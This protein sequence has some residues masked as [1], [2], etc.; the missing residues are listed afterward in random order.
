MMKVRAYL[1]FVLLGLAWDSNFIFM[2]WATGLVTAT[3][4]TLLQVMFGCLSVFLFA[5]ATKA[6]RWSHVRYAHH[7]FIMSLLAVIVYHF[8]CTKN[9]PISLSSGTGMLSGTMPGLTLL[10]SYLFLREEHFS[11]K[12]I[13]G[14]VVGLVGV[15]LIA[16]PWSQ[17]MKIDV[18]SVLYIL[19]GVVSLAGSF[20]YARKFIS[21]LN[22]SPLVSST[23]QLGAAVIVLL[24]ITG[25]NGIENITSDLNISSAVIFGFGGCGTGLAFILYYYIVQEM[26]AVAASSVTY[27]NPVVGLFIGVYCVAEPFNLLDF[28][29]AV[30]TLFGIYLMQSGRNKTGS[31]RARFFR[32][33]EI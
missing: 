8:A 30:A 3:Q 20:V 28:I 13:A 27:L 15:F 12:V 14:A 9:A 5:V 32:R 6:L 26:G 2:K 33:I 1:A 24:S 23:Y 21:P 16:R 7:F 19:V 4:A 25:F 22:L 31:T 17:D 29:A 10:V 18:E 11:L